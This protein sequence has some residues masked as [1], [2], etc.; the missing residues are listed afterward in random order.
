MKTKS[1][2][3]RTG[4]GKE[5]LHTSFQFSKWRT[6]VVVFTAHAYAIGLV[7]VFWPHL[8]RDVPSPG[9]GRHVPPKSHVGATWLCKET[10]RLLRHMLLQPINH[11][12]E[13]LR[14]NLGKKISDPLS[15]PVCYTVSILVATK[16][17]KIS[18][19]FQF[20]QSTSILI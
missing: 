3:S 10:R 17:F 2:H 18:F 13:K 15:F 7:A 20:F 9:P 1:K 14:I 5:I 16:I 4:K 11:K 12:S 6:I 8:S 19:S